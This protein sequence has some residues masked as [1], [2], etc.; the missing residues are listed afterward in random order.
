MA[1]ASF[2]ARFDEVLSPHRSEIVREH[3]AAVTV[4]DWRA[5]LPIL[6]GSRVTLRDLRPADAPA[7]LQLLT[8]E[9]VTRFIS[10][11]PTTVEG[12]ERF[13]VWANAQRAAGHYICFAVVPHGGETAIGILQVRQM[14]QGCGT[15]EW[16]FAIGQAFWG[17]GLFVE[18]A[19]LVLAFTFDTLGVHRLEARAAAVNARGNG[20]L[21]KLGARREAVL[22]KSFSRNGRDLDQALWS[23]LEEDWRLARR[24]A[25][26]VWA[27]GRQGTE[28][29]TTTLH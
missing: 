18:A 12:F 13:I 11:P 8:A 7:L 6:T 26:A 17:T 10:P 15:A 21:Q 5:T 27:A 14:A 20:A 1:L 16:G 4:S 3:S 9:E 28:R 19:E 2:T 23:I 22:R 25:K 29:T 24:S